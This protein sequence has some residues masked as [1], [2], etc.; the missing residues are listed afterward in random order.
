MKILGIETSCDETA[1]ALIEG[2][3]SVREGTVKISVLGNAVHSQIEAH[4]PHGGVFPMLAKREHAK[5]LIP[6]LR[7][8]LA[9]GGFLTSHR[10]SSSEKIYSNVLKN[11]RIDLSHMLEREQELLK[12]FE[13]FIP[14]IEKPPIDAIAVT[15]GPGLEPALWVGINFARALSLVWDTPLIPVNHMEGHIFSALLKRDIPSALNSS[16]LPAIP[17]RGIS[18]RETS[19]QLQA[20]S[21]PALALLVS[22]AHTELVLMESWFAYKILG[23]TRDDAAG[24]AF[25]KAARMLGLPYPGGPEIA[26]L[27][28]RA[29]AD[30]L[31]RFHTLPRP[32][33]AA[34]NYDFSFSGLKTALLYTLKKILILG[35]IERAALAREFEDAVIETLVAKTKKAAIECGARSIIVGGGVSANKTLRER[36]ASFADT[37]PTKSAQFAIHFPERDLSTDN[38]LMIALA[39]FIHAEN[40]LK[41]RNLQGSMPLKAQGVMP[42]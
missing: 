11:I 12:Q 7:Q 21:L 31:P 33:L 41:K 20:L 32:M 6:I 37:E 29:R 36:L 35:E 28:E 3:G 42:L 5:N 24:E 10:L 19:Y 2:A 17:L 39:G 18:R 1:I 14:T 8:V 16:K 25:D 15:V 13:K 23:Q 22:G 9:E 38:A 30:N 26:R 4:R 40:D 27:A 34:A